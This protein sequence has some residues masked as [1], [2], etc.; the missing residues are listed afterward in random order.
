MKAPTFWRMNFMPGTLLAFGLS[1]HQFLFGAATPQSP[2]TIEMQHIELRI[3][4]RKRS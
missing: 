3:G 1:G 4:R 2:V